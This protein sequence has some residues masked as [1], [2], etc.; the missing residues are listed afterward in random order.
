MK[1]SLD[2]RLHLP[3]Q[4]RLEEVDGIYLPDWQPNAPGFGIA[5]IFQAGRIRSKPLL[6][7]MDFWP[8]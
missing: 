3:P 2:R 1:H 5:V 8:R 7:E 6:E 4:N